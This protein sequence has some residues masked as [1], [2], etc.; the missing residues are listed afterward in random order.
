MSPLT[1]I[2]QS[3]HA[4]VEDESSIYHLL[5]KSGSQPSLSIDEVVVRVPSVGERHVVE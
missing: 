1:A 2:L 3:Y 5:K 4:K